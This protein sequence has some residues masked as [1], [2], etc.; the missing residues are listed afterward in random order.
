MV[1][2]FPE[3]LQIQQLLEKVSR[4]DCRRQPSDTSHRVHS[5]INLNLNW[6]KWHNRKSFQNLNL[7]LPWRENLN[8]YPGILNFVGSVQIST[9]GLETHWNQR[10]LNWFWRINSARCEG[11]KW[12]RGV[13]W[14]CSQIYMGLLVHTSTRKIFWHVMHTHANT[15]TPQTH[16]QKNT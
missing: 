12:D 11:E 14:I 2:L 8:H 5:R 9:F 15:L 13:C 4:W 16:R 7:S 3:N 6:S 10:I 1:N